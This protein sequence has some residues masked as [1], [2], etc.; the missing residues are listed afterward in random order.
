MDAPRAG[1]NHQNQRLHFHHN[2]CHPLKTIEER[3]TIFIIVSLA[4]P[5]LI[6]MVQTKVGYLAI[7]PFQRF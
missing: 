6:N 3:H 5:K 1:V 7:S 4:F 2:R